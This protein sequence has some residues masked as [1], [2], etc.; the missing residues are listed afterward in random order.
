MIEKEP[1]VWYELNAVFVKIVVPSLIGI[2]IKLATQI[3]KEKMT[4]LRVIL[5]FTTGI[6]C[7]YFIYPFIENTKY[8]PLIIGI[9]SISGEKIMEFL[10]YKWDIDYFLTSLM[11]VFR[12]MILKIFTK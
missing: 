12:Q 7:A 10:I 9:V 1:N 4:F 2:S 8:T 5:S 6:G 11:E 3:K